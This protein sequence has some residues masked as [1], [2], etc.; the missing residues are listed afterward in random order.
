MI[1]GTGFAPFRGGPLFYL[2]SQSR[3]R[4]GATS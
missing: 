2:A 3:P 1:F 4:E